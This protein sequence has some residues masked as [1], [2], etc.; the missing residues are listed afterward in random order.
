MQIVHVEHQIDA[1]FG[2]LPDKSFSWIV[3]MSYSMVLGLGRPTAAAELH[4]IRDQQT[5]EYPDPLSGSIQS[6]QHQVANRFL[7]VAMHSTVSGRG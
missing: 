7:T 3:F 4:P 2:S 5:G 6:K 1:F